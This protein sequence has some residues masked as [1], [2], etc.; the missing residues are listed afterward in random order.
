MVC[1]LL[2]G[3]LKDAGFRNKWEMCKSSN[4]LWVLFKWKNMEHKFKIQNFIYDDFF[5]TLSCKSIAYG[6]FFFSVHL[7]GK[8]VVIPIPQV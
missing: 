2:L 5:F 6:C 4:I 7:S 1:K 8:S 3:K